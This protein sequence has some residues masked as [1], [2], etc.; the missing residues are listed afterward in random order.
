[1]RRDTEGS[2]CLCLSL[3]AM[4]DTTRRQSSANPGSGLSPD[5]RSPITLMLNFPASGTVRNML[6]KT[7][8]LWLLLQQ[9]ERTNTDL[10]LLYL[11]LLSHIMPHSSGTVVALDLLLRCELTAHSHAP[12][13]LLAQWISHHFF[14]WHPHYLLWEIFPNH[15]SITFLLR[16][17]ELVFLTYVLTLCFTETAS[18]AFNSALWSVVFIRW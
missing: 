18:M 6:F 10:K 17:E 15:S 16:S 14:A 1:M 2:L 13:V 7:P 5:T 9:C 4:W 11:P 12:H 8:N 3:P